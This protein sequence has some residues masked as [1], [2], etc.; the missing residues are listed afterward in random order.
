MPATLL[1]RLAL[2]LPLFA[3]LSCAPAALAQS[4]APS[5]G[6]HGMLLFGGR[7]GLFLSHLPMFHRPHDTQVVLQV[8]LANRRHEAQLQRELAAHPQLW[9]VVPER[10][11][12]DRL[13]PGARQ[14]L[15]SFHAD[16]VRGHFERGGKTIHANDEF[17]VDRVVFDHR[18][19]PTGGPGAT[20]VYRVVDA[21]PAAREHFLVH[22]IATRPDADHVVRVLTPAPAALP[23]QIE[24]A[25]GPALAATPEAL[26]HALGQAG[27]S[28]AR[29]DRA[30]YLE[31]GDLE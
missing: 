13:A 19:A 6:E 12:L 7:D 27:A 16:V 31:T 11:E 21:G 8:H 15:R 3:A 5:M 28:S 17:I 10:F 14:P 29:V 22:W 23:P 30:I 9:T 25:R 20:L 1:A 26:Q 4:P 18:L 24:L 2:A